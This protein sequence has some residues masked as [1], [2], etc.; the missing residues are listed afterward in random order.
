MTFSSR[1]VNL[2]ADLPPKGRAG[3]AAPTFIMAGLGKR[4]PEGAQAAGQPLGEVDVPAVVTALAAR[5]KGKNDDCNRGFTGM[6]PNKL[7]A[8]L[9]V[10][11]TA[12][13]AKF[14]EALGFTP[15]MP[16][17]SAELASFRFARN[18]F[19]IHFFEHKKL[20]SAMS[21]FYVG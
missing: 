1:V 18:D 8:N 16:E 19:I 20:L 3:L 9:A 5:M 15:N 14:Y 21:I 10:A 7:W 17:P 2:V 12:R 13:T 6:T 4:I 11:D